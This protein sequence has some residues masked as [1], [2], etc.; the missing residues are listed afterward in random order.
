MNNL[1]EVRALQG[2]ATP[3]FVR[4]APALEHRSG[5]QTRWPSVH[6]ALGGG[7][8]SPCSFSA[9]SKNG[10]SPLT[11]LPVDIETNDKTSSESSKASEKQLG[12]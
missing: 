3:G 6:R 10:R 12:L 5:E 7:T 4:R 1:S 2:G 8:R 9:P 11:L